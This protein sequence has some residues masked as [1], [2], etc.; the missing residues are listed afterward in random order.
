V[1][2]I[3]LSGGPGTGKSSILKA[4]SKLGYA[5][6][7]ESFR[8]FIP[9][10]SV[11]ESTFNFQNSPLRFSELLFKS[12]V[13][14]YHQAVHNETNFYDRSLIDVVAYLVLDEI[15]APKEWLDFIENNKYHNTVLYFPFWEEIYHKDYKRVENITLAKKIDLQLRKTYKELGYKI[16]EIP[17]LSIPKRVEFICEFLKINI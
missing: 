7:E 4:L 5:C 14:Q 6:K 3:I 16:I 13:Q 15:D 17:K 11:A 12:R 10:D 9:E 1:K 8:E 2:R